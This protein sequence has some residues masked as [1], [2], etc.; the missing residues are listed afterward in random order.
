MSSA[1]TIHHREESLLDAAGETLLNETVQRALRHCH[2]EGTTAEVYCNSRTPAGK[3]NA[4]WLEFGLRIV[5]ATSGQL[6]IGCIQR[7]ATSACEFHS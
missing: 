5:Y 6:F 2:T 3:S 7:S 4:G 1:I